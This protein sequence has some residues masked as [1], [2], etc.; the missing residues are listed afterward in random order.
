MMRSSFLEGLG[1]AALAMALTAPV[2]HAIPED[3]HKFL[4]REALTETLTVEEEAAL[5][6]AEKELFE[7]QQAFKMAEEDLDD[8]IAL[9]EQRERELLDAL[10][11]LQ[12][13]IDAMADPAD[14]EELTQDVADATR[15]L[16]MAEG[17]TIAAREDF[18]EAK[19]SRDARAA[20]VIALEEEIEK[21]GLLVGELSD[22]QVF[23][24]KRKLNGAIASGLLPLGIDSQHLQE[25]LDGDF[26]KVRINAF[27]TA[28][29]Q[30]AIFERHA[31]RFEAKAAASGDSR[32]QDNA[33]A[34]R[35]R[36]ERQFDK[37]QDKA[38][39][40]GAR[41]A[42]KEARAAAQEA[43][44]EATQSAI[45]EERRKGARGEAKGQGSS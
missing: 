21:T 37:F 44:K 25:I 5:V 3:D 16:E 10:K 2:A 40:I 12:D 17:E 45:A 33:D 22:E 11:D 24:M 20:V 32:F 39:E 42:A 15:A 28:F 27:L 41:E 1:I 6:V 23:A 26:G 31:V 14:I 13:A 30:R 18:I 36:G 9:E 43:A 34:M 19:A 29:Q 8:A 4:D 38:D 35:D 7:A